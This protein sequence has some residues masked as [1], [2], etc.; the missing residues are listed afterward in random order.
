MCPRC[1]ANAALMV[2]G[3]TSTGWL[4]AIVINQVRVTNGA[5]KSSQN[6]NE[7]RIDHEQESDRTSD[8]RLAS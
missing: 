5:K 1:I 7:G 3:A 6:T 8:N 4:A 2:A